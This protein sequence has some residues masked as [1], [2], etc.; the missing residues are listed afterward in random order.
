MIFHGI[1][2]HSTLFQLYISKRGS[3]D[4][5]GYLLSD[6]IVQFL[7]HNQGRVAN[8]TK[9]LCYLRSNATFI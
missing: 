9:S 7:T 5:I 2:V 8:N 6:L 4:Y 1:R 3:K